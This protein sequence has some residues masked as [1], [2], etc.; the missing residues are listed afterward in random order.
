MRGPETCRRSACFCVSPQL[1]FVH[2]KL[3]A[4]GLFAKCSQKVDLRAHSEVGANLPE[5]P[6][7][8]TLF[9]TSAVILLL[10]AENSFCVIWLKVNGTVHQRGI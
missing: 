7:P 10:L 6:S 9:L 4:K 2:T 8:P 5:A 1:T 3:I